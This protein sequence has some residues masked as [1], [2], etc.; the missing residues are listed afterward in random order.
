MLKTLTC[1]FGTGNLLV[2]L[3]SNGGGKTTLMLAIL[4][5][6][7]SYKGSVKLYGLQ[8]TKIGFK[9]RIAWVSQNAVNIPESSKITVRELIS[10]GTVT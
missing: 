10:L 2:L 3:G 9:S 5:V 8:N 7:K 6:L 4:G 1:K